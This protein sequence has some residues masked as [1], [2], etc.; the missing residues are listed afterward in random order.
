MKHSMDACWA[1]RDRWRKAHPGFAANRNHP[2]FRSIIRKAARAAKKKNTKAV[3]VWRIGSKKKPYCLVKRNGRLVFK[4]RLV[5]QE[6]LR[7]KLGRDEWVYH[8]N[9]DTLDNRPENLELFLQREG[10][11]RLN[12]RWA[13]HFDQCI[14]CGT[15]KHRHAAKG[16]CFHCYNQNKKEYFVRYRQVNKNR[17][18]E[19]Q[20]QRRHEKRQARQ[21]TVDSFSPGK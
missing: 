14:R 16:V 6:K 9:G 2:R 4:H 20:R 7:R 8:R 21:K 19:R 12:G 10:G 18:A 11:A 17:D 1:G 5:M 3:H 13:R 15:R